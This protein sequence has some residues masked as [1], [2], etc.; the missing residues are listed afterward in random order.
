MRWLYRYAFNSFRVLHD[1]DGAVIK[2]RY[3][4]P[5]GT[6]RPFLPFEEAVQLVRSVQQR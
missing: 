4:K 5:D 2:T 6:P 3:L 1:S